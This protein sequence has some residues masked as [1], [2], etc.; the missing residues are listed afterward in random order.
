MTTAHISHHTCR[1]GHARIKP[2]RDL[3][4]PLRAA[5]PGLLAA[6]GRTANARCTQRPIACGTSSHPGG[7]RTHSQTHSQTW[8]TLAALAFHDHHCLREPRLECASHRAVRTR[9]E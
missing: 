7:S 9:R 4:A 6:K 1:S 5:A 3:P 8:A 2:A